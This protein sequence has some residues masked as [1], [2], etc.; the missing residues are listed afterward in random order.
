V[1]QQKEKKRL[2]AQTALSYLKEGMSLGVGT[3]STVDFFID[4]LPEHSH[5][6]AAIVSSSEASTK[7]LKNLKIEV[8]DLN[9]VSD[10]DVYVDGADEAT[11]HLNLI[12]GGGGALT[13]EKILA[14][15][16]RRFICIVDDTKIV[17]VLGK[18]PIPV[19]VIPM[20]QS[21]VARQIVKAGGQP[22]LREKFVSDN[23]NQILDVHN[24][25]VTDPVKLEI[26][27]NQIPGVVTV[28]IF[29]RRKADILLIGEKNDVITLD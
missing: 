16:S 21:Y 10:V 28:G 4:A 26:E 2:V 14:G 27:L 18:F 6:L 25:A 24:L 15:A 13:R 17:D 3:G 22:I 23:G 29:A 7:K 20:A 1:D 11:K 19:E 12:K 5:Y 9:R 8:T